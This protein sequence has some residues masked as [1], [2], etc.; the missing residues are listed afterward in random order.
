MAHGV[1]PNFIDKHEELH[2]PELQK[3]LA[4]KHN[5]NERY[6]TSGITFQS[7]LQNFSSVDKVLTMDM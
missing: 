6:S 5:A 4:I 7:F 1:H 2:R 3:G